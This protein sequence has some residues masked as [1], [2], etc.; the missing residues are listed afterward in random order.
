MRRAHRADVVTYF[1]SA[2]SPAASVVT[3]DGEHGRI[4]TSTARVSG[5]IGW[6]HERHDWAGL[7]SII[8]VTCKRETAHKITEETR[9]FVSSLRADNPSK[10]AH[11]IRAHWAIENNLH[12]VLDVAFDEDGN[13]TRNGHSAANLA[14]ETVQETQR[15]SF[16]TPLAPLIRGELSGK[17]P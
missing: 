17:S 7:Q 4:E 11:S 13:R 5:D 16:L 12:W 3:H 15:S 8:V 14:I 2:L 10:L 1:N 9:Y 6:L